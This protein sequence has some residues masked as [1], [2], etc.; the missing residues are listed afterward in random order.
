MFDIIKTKRRVNGYGDCWYC[1]EIVVDPV[2][3]KVTDHR[4]IEAITVCRKRKCRAEADSG[5]LDPLPDN[6]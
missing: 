6:D 4:D 2:I 3:F 1:N 5:S